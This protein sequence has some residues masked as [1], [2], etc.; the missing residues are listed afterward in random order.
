MTN[1]LTARPKQIF[2]N[3]L[4]LMIFVLLLSRLVRTLI[5]I[6]QTWT[7]AGASS[8][9]GVRRTSFGS[10]WNCPSATSSAT[11]D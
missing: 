2:Q 9:T 10:R 1:S 8:R 7:R 4:A 6:L 5:R 3:A 11:V